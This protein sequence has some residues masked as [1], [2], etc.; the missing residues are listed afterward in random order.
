M[1]R[2][3]IGQKIIALS[4][5]AIVLAMLW[6]PG[7]QSQNQKQNTSNKIHTKSSSYQRGTDDAPVSVKLLNTGKTD[8]ETAQDAE[9]IQESNT[10]E[11]WNR[12]LTFAL[13]IATILQF[14]ALVYQGRKLRDTVIEMEKGTK[15]TLEVARAT[16]KTADATKETID[17]YIAGERAY[18]FPGLPKLRDPGIAENFYGGTMGGSPPLVDYS[19]SNIGKTAAILEEIRT[20]IIIAQKL[21]DKPSYKESITFIT[22]QPIVNGDPFTSPRPC[23]YSER[24][25]PEEVEAIR[26]GSLNIFF[27]GYARYRDIFCHVYE[28][29]FAFRV[30]R[31]SAFVTGGNTYNYD[32]K[33]DTDE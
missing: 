23:E 21:P 16:Q 31:S 14:A 15:A 1:K 18:I 22:E 7:A 6:I 4:I 10:S 3:K 24:L 28:R 29:G 2:Y 26:D 27:F 30:T 5:L 13:V 12:G 17:S 20:E 33:I 11:R 19:I 32:K 8:A 9:R 25:T